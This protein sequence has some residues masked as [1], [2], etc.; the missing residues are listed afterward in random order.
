MQDT[1]N[2]IYPYISLDPTIGYYSATNAAKQPALNRDLSDKLNDIVVR[3][4]PFDALNQMIKDWR[5]A[6]GDQIRM[7]FQQAMNNVQ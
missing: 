2:A 5:A 7:E 4:Q 6:G 1:Q 3:R